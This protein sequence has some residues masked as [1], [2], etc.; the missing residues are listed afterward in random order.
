MSW[1]RSG[2]HGISISNWFTAAPVAVADPS[3][4]LEEAR[5]AMLDALGAAGA[6]KRPSLSLRIRTGPNAAVLWELRPELMMIASQLHGEVEG[7]KRL[8]RVTSLFESL[9]P[10][11]SGGSKR[12]S[13][14]LARARH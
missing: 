7:R 14:A 6:R 4:A 9:L 3:L 2:L 5:Q 8:A 1:I 10:V 12:K 11:A 13:A